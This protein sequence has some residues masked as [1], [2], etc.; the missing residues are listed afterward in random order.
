MVVS[1]DI[2]SDFGVQLAPSE[3]L[4]SQQKLVVHSSTRVTIYLL[5]M[6]HLYA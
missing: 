6:V 1:G 2:L 5:C 4:K 3:F